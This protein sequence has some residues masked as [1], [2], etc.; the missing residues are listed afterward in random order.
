MTPR[1]STKRKPSEDEDIEM[2]IETHFKDLMEGCVYDWVDPND[3]I[4]FTM[5]RPVSNS[6]VLK[7][8]HLFDG[9]SDG[10][11]INTG[12]ISCESDTSIVVKLD[13]TL[14]VH[15]GDHFR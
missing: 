12:G 5:T 13:G 4:P 1:K 10:E 7:L 15:V 9:S 11:N 14:L 3:C 8:M 6:G 2:S